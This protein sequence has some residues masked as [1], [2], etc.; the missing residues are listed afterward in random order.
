M[1]TTTKQIV[2]FEDRAWAKAQYPR[3]VSNKVTIEDIEYVFGI[4]YHHGKQKYYLEVETTK[5]HEKR[6]TYAG[7][8]FHDSIQAAK[9][10]IVERFN[11]TVL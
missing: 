11:L 6:S 2:E 9:D 4:G 8:T 10:K 5:F 7:M 3:L 1:T